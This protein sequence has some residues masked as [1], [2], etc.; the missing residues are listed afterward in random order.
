[1]SVFRVGHH[2][3]RLPAD[4]L[5]VADGHELHV[6]LLQEAIREGTLDRILVPEQALDILAQQLVAEIACGER[7]EDELFAMCRRAWPYRHLERSQFDRIVAMLRDGFSTR[8]GRR[9][10]YLHHDRVHGTLRPRRG[11]RLAAITNG[12]AIPDTADYDVVL[13]P[14]E[15]RVGSVNEDFAVESMAGNIF[16]LGNAS[17]RI[18]KIEPGKVRV[19]DGRGQPPTIPFWFGEAPARSEELSDA[20]CRLREEV[21]E[22]AQVDR[23]AAVAWLGERHGLPAGPAQ[24]L[25]DYLLAA[26]RTLGAIPTRRRVILERFF[27]ESG[28]MQVVVHS[29]FGSR[30]NRAWGLALRKRFCRKFNFELQAAATED[31]IILSL[32]VTHSFPLDEVFQYLHPDTVRDVLTQALLDAPMFNVRWRWNAGRALAILRFRGGRRVPPQFQRM[33]ADDLVSV[34]FPDQLACLENIQGEREVPDHPLVDQ[35]IDDCLEEA[36]DIDGLI[37]LLED[38]RAGRIELIARDLTEPSPLTAEILT[39]KPYAFLDDAPLEERRTQAVISRRWLDPNEASDLGA[40]D[41]AAID[42]V[43]EESRPDPRDENELH[44][45]LV[46]AGFLTDVEIE[47]DWRPWLAEL[48]E[49]GRLTRLRQ[50]NGDL[51]VAAER[52]AE[53]RALLPGSPA[54]PPLDLPGSLSRVGGEG[55]ALREILRGRLEILGP[56]AEAALHAP[57]E[58]G[59]GA[60]GVSLAAV[61]SALAELEGEGFAMRGRFTPRT[62]AADLAL[63]W[64]ERR[65][66]AR[67]HRYTLKRLRAAIQPVS[68]S[69]FQRFLLDWQHVSPGEHT[70]GQ[71]G[72]ESVVHQLEGFELP[73]ASWEEEILPQ[74]VEAYDPDWLDGLCIAGKLQ[75]RRRSPSATARGEGRAGPIRSTPIALIQRRHGPLF[76]SLSDCA[77]AS[78][79]PAA[80]RV[81]EFL[82]RHGA[83]FFDDI[84]APTGMLGTQLEAVISELVSAGR[85]TSDSFLGLRALL[86]PAAKKKSTGSRRRTVA[87]GLEDA[88]RWT[89]L[90]LHPES[91]SDAGSAPQAPG[92]DSPAGGEA[93]SS[94]PPP[95]HPGRPRARGSRSPGPSPAAPLG[96][97]LSSHPRARDRAAPVAR[98]PASVAA[99]RSARRD[100]W[101]TFRQRAFR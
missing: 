77:Q 94:A 87:Y 5:D 95:E 71:R 85:V 89:A 75:W 58:S 56:V 7:Q 29:P 59:E 19:E 83:S 47:D 81:L 78:L 50:P 38:M 31:A 101:R 79:S 68:R 20:V 86:V 70:T 35:T 10:A 52:F 17:W 67:I 44:D 90:T 24:Q 32:G 30:I 2:L 37:A 15:I 61:Q 92:T 36:M 74:R 73:A 76:A 53:L 23:D 80:A 42:R 65:L 48:L 28:G 45:A 40:L 62:H 72:V 91:H 4:F 97:R 57:L 14:G 54:E 63:E 21:A 33:N 66:L 11:A 84:A 82:E 55:E 13:E 9:G 18:L 93:P 16:Q 43:R 8:N 39:A 41:Q 51:W 34:V 12:G 3:D 96:R 88:G 98:P 99:A 27:D 100:P 25:V 46:L 6:R 26:V 64:C 1:M 69:A 22:R 60:G 49:Q